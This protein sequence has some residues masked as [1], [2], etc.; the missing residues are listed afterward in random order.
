MYIARGCQ[1]GK[2]KR[3]YVPDFGGYVRDS[4]DDP[5]TLG[6][7]ICKGGGYRGS[8]VRLSDPTEEKLKKRIDKWVRARRR[9]RV[10]RGKRY[11]LSDSYDCW[12]C[13]KTVE[14]STKVMDCTRT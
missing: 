6:R 11:G 14:N 10:Q 3:F 9:K 12:L 4:T 2:E 1:H 8:T 7:Q 5:G 13:G